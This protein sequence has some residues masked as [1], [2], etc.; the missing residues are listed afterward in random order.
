MGVCADSRRL[1]DGLAGWTECDASSYGGD[2]EAEETQCDG[3]DNDCDGSTDENLIGPGCPLQAGVCSGSVQR[4]GAQDWLPCDATDYGVDYEVD[5]EACDGLDNDCDGATDQDL[6]P[7]ACALQ[8][9]VCAGSQRPCLGAQGFG[10]CDVNDYGASFQDV[11][12]LCD[13]L[14]NDCDAITDED[15][16]CTQGETKSCSVDEGECQVGIQ[17]CDQDGIWGDCNG[18]LPADEGCD[19]LDNNCDGSTD[20]NL[21]GSSCP[22]QEG[23]CA[24]A[25]QVCRGT[26]GWECDAETYGA[27]YEQEETSCDDLDNDCDGLTDETG[28]GQ[29]D[30][31]QTD[32]GSVVHPKVK[33]GCSCGSTPG[34]FVWYAPL[35]LA[36]I[37]L[38]R[39][40]RR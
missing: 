14:D 21:T 20:E 31:G 2:Y 40:R 16:P 25:M 10:D 35:M 22:L 24:G 38:G 4:C 19:G 34:S 23:V 26:A 7:P 13:D 36:L 11:E 15:C 32:G 37:W 33:G 6:D 12:T 1:C 29:V 27:D 8:L 9:G 17:E 30:G 18:V 3:L 5:E 28:C 39:R